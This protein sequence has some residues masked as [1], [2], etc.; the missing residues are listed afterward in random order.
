MMKVFLAGLGALLCAS[1]ALADNPPQAP[2][3]AA[4]PIAVAAEKLIC[5]VDGETG[6]RLKKTKVCKT[7]QEWD[8]QRRLGA[9]QIDNFEK[10]NPNPL[11]SQ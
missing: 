9:R 4:P 10:T 11:P 7:A 2:Q 3:P 5:R 8:E 6:S 1:V